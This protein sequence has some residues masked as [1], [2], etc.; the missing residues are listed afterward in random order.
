MGLADPL[1]LPDFGVDLGPELEAG[2]AEH[3]VEIEAIAAGPW[4]PTFADTIEALERAGSRL[5]RAERLFADAS[6]SR[7]TPALRALEA[8]MLPRLA[9][10]HDAV[11]LDPRIFARIADL[12]ARRGEYKLS[13]GDPPFTPG[14]EGGGVID[15]IG[16]GVQGRKI[17]ERVVLGLGIRTTPA[18]GAGGT[19]R[20][21]YYCS[22]D[23]AIPAPASPP[24]SW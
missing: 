15:A 6:G 11:G 5:H 19:Y 7:S 9:A 3:R 18:G 4:P 10:H 16:P 14:L 2:M 12:M 20:S 8:E 22:P 17:G 24:T 13:S 1:G 21:H 23:Q